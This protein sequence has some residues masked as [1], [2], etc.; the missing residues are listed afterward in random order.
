MKRRISL[1]TA[2]TLWNSVTIALL[3]GAFGVALSLLNQN[4]LRAEI[5]DQLRHE[6]LGAADS[7]P[8]HPHDPPPFGMPNPDGRQPGPPDG[9]DQGRPDQGG[10]DRGGPDRGGL[11]EG[12]P[13]QGGPSQGGP[14]PLFP[15]KPGQQGP[16][17]DDRPPRPNVYAEANRVADIRRPR[18][19]DN[20]GRPRG[21][22]STDVAL[23]PEALKRALAGA[24]GFSTVVRNGQS[25]RV[26][27]APSRHGPRQD[28]AVQIGHELTDVQFLAAGQARVLL[29]L[30]PIAAALAAGGSVLITRRALRPVRDV[31]RTARQIG[32]SDLSRRLDVSGD[33][34]L[35]ELATTFNAMLA[36]LE[37]SFSEQ[38]RAYEALRRAYEEQRR[39]TADASHELRTPLTRLRLTTSAALD[40][41]GGEPELRKA[42][43]GADR[44]AGSMTRLVE[45]LLTLARADAGQLGL[46]KQPEDLRVV[47]SDALS[48]SVAEDEPR[49]E[50][51]FPDRPV[52]A[53]VDADHLRR[54]VVNL[55]VNALRHTPPEGKVRVSVGSDG[56]A[57]AIQV[58]DTG[59]GIAPEHLGHLFEPFYRV[60]SARTRKDGGSGLG[61]AISKKVVEAH[62][63]Q[64]EIRS[65]VGAGT[66][67]RVLIPTASRG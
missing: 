42:L 44:A 50:T 54:V 43:E 59:E 27:T 9:P 5:D 13:G 66:V 49:L 62:D 52:M 55:V 60:D 31:T 47:V 17:Q 67:V 53:A 22:F 6:G 3:L 23:D 39:F 20:D 41:H 24:A 2:L 51:E 37:L 11:G 15:I 16:Q 38:K 61:L 57:A 7:G 58:A 25:I 63:G 35:A 8:P 40:G 14:G 33:D 29:L 10:P 46:R 26:F 64:I 12:G 65:R 18:F 28:G 36:R 4:V 19:F 34:E 56:A 48:E 30:L 32:G 1:R 21:P 45:Q